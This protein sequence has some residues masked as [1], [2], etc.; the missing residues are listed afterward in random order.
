MSWAVRW[1]RIADDRRQPLSWEA[2]ALGADFELSPGNERLYVSMRGREEFVPAYRAQENVCVCLY[3]GGPSNILKSDPKVSGS[4]FCST[5]TLTLARD[6]QRLW[7]QS[8]L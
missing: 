4:A 1:G 6:L 7:T 8:V 2:F 5:G 3:G